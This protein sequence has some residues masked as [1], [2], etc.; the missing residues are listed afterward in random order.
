[1]EVLLPQP[2]RLP[3]GF[4]EFFGGDLAGLQQPPLLFLRDLQ[5]PRV[6]LVTFPH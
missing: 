5:Q 3:L 6:V 4:L 1:M 2:V